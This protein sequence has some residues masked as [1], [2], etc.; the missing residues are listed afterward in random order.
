MTHVVFLWSVKKAVIKMNTKTVKI[1]FQQHDILV[2]LPKSY[3][4]RRHH[5]YPLMLVQEG[6]ALFKDVEADVIFA[7]LVPNDRKLEL[8]P[9]HA[10]VDGVNYDGGADACK[11]WIIE[12]LIPYLRKCFNIS[13]EHKDIGIGGVSLGGLFTLYTLLK[14]PETFGYYIL[15]SPSIWYPRFV[16]FM[17]QQEIIK[18][19]KRIYWYV[20][21]QEGRQHISIKQEMFTQTELGVDILNELMISEN[22]S[23]YYETN[24]RGNHEM[25]YFKKYFARAIKKLF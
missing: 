11:K 6:Y 25:S 13:Q 4:E 24:K 20:G 14:D 10:V 12:Q 19:D 22:T 7:D 1:H 18:Q 15:I 21:E 17:K 9:W 8:T 23:F 2:K 5:P 16:E 3:D